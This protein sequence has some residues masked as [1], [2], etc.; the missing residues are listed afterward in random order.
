MRG[1]GCGRGAGGAGGMRRGR[2]E[3]KR[4]GG[5]ER[6]RACRWMWEGV[7]VEVCDREPFAIATHE[8]DSI[9]SFHLA[10]IL[11]FQTIPKLLLTPLNQ[12]IGFS[13]F[14]CL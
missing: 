12:L 13:I 8:Y 9:L 4:R 1:G 7:V 10:Y 14:V 11:I 3:R 2:L 5:L 6:M